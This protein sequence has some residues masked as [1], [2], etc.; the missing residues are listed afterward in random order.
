MEIENKD[1]YGQIDPQTAQ[2][3]ETPTKEKQNQTETP[4]ITTP[5]KENEGTNEELNQKEQ[6]EQERKKQEEDLWKSIKKEFPALSNI[7]SLKKE[8]SKLN[9][10]LS[11]KANFT[12]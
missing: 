2:Q 12:N 4:E 11:F 1:L 9:T 7:S 5:K 10:L 3:G 8:T 6:E